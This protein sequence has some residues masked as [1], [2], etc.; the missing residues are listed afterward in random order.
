MEPFRFRFMLNHVEHDFFAFPDQIKATLVIVS[1]DSPLAQSSIKIV[2]RGE[3]LLLKSMS[4]M[5]IEDA[6]ICQVSRYLVN[7]GVEVLDVDLSKT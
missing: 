5:A 7:P 6:A 1:E 2:I 3:Q 4:L